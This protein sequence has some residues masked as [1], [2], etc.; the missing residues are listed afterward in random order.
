MN[1]Y[2]TAALLIV[3]IISCLGILMF[4]SGKIQ[5]W[6]FHHKP[7]PIPPQ[8]QSI[9][10]LYPLQQCYAPVTS[11]S[12]N[13]AHYSFQQEETFLLFP[14]ARFELC[15]KS[16]A[17][18]P[19]SFSGV[20]EPQRFSTMPEIHFYKEAA[21]DRFGKKMSLITEFQT[22]D[23]VFDDNVF[24]DTKVDL[25]FLKNLLASEVLR[26]NIVQLL[27][28]GWSSI[29][30]FGRTSP[31]SVQVEDSALLS[32]KKEDIDA[33]LNAVKVIAS[34]L[35]SIQ[36][37]APQKMSYDS[38]DKLLFANVILGLGAIALFIL[39]RDQWLVLS[40]NFE[41]NSQLLSLLVWVSTLPVFFVILKGH[42][43]S[44]KAFL[45][46]ACL[47]FFS[48]MLGTNPFLRCLNAQLDNSPKK[49]VTVEILEKSETAPNIK[50]TYIRIGQS[51]ITPEATILISQQKLASLDKEVQ[52][53]VR[54]GALSEVWLDTILSNPQD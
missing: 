15:L 3:I 18:Y 25:S 48:L 54:S 1:V 14:F 23:A 2:L 12:S 46:N 50:Y 19:S 22:G 17:S 37:D 20:N 45:Y 36:V 40:E 31:I 5:R 6:R 53:Q 9:H 29:T 44:M 41:T 34:T 35:P 10:A 4:L 43:F 39:G 27:S 21:D 13:I 49:E 52:I 7:P 8:A 33:H 28:D 11:M 30:L 24:I 47:G 42:S 32:S 51:E 16:T 38:G 26:N